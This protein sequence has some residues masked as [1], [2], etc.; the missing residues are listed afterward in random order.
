VRAA[1]LR[2]HGGRRPLLRRYWWLRKSLPDV[3]GGL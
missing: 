3:R 1:H 2:H